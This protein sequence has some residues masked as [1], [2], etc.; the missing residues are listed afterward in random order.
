L[1]RI[2]LI[3]ADDEAA[4]RQTL[5]RRLAAVWPESELVGEA[6][7]GAQALE[8]IETLGPRVAFLDIRMPGLT[9]M[10]V[11]R[12]MAGTCL[13]VFVT[14]YDQYAVDAF[15]N[16][17]V[18]YLLKPVTAERLVKTVRRLK[19]RLAENPAPLADLAGLVETILARV[20]KPEMPAPLKWIRVLKGETVQLVAVDDVYYFQVRDKYTAVVT[21]KEEFLIRKP[22][23]ELAAI[24]DPQVF[25]R[26][27]RSVIVNVPYI[28]RVDR[29]LTGRL[30]LNLKD[31]PDQLTVSRSYSHL[32]KRM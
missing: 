13:V 21:R 17:A 8:M 22:I 4:L 23:C 20:P 9:G 2:K 18:D 32:F 10:D 27:H 6:E 1:D 24:L 30:T 7:N 14:A 29:T 25:W 26:I 19:Q 12:R 16:A 11:A 15:E 3:V 31:L 28:H 5:A